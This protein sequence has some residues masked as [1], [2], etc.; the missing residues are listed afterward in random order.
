VPWWQ[1]NM[2]EKVVLVNE[3]NEV[4]GLMPKME[5]HE[6]GLLHRA[7]SILLYNSK[8][9]MLIQQRAKT[10]YHWPLIWSNAVCSHPR[11]N[12]DFQDAAQRRLKEE[13]NITCSLKEVYRFIYKAKDEQTG[14]IEHEY[15]VVY[16]GQFDGEIPFNP[17]EIESIRW[18]ALDSLS[19]DIEDQPEVYSFWFKE[20]LKNVR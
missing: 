3:N 20:I 13:L 8:G 9:E 5:A 7:I 12:E 19:Q 2:E 17:N 11:E 1:K 15:D 16:K 14:L 4:L 6:K 18:I 10:K